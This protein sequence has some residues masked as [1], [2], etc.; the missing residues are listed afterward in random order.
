MPVITALEVSQRNANRVKL[1]LDDK[2]A[3]DLPLLEAARLQR[4]QCLTQA[5]VDA[6]ADD[7]LIQTAYDRAVH[8]LSYR[9]RS[10]EEVRRYLTKKTMAESTVAVVFDRLQ[11]REYLDDLAFARF[12]I[13]NRNRFKPMAPRALRYE[14]RQKGI[15]DEIINS[16]LSEVDAGDAAYRAA[17]GRVHRYKG[18]SRQ[19]FRRKLSGLL[20]R[21]GFDMETVNEVLLRLQLE[22]EESECGFFG[23]DTDE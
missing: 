6:L 9:P 16:L 12:W 3:M 15:G 2:F 22:L 1:Y 11:A 8:F 18:D 21:R 17:K 19:V 4:G 10:S 13:E 20:R 5:E 14:L 23:C 7:K